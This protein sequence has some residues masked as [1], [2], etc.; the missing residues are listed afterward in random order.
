MRTNNV[1]R[2][3]ISDSQA[4]K[5]LHKQILSKTKSTTNIQKSVPSTA[6][7]KYKKPDNFTKMM[8][9]SSRFTIASFRNMSSLTPVNEIWEK[10]CVQTPAYRSG[11]IKS[12]TLLKNKT[13]N[14]ST[15]CKE[16]MSPPVANHYKTS[17]LLPD[18]RAA[19][20]STR[21]SWIP[22]VRP[23]SRTM[24][25][26][27]LKVS[28]AG[29]SKSDIKKSL[30]KSVRILGKMNTHHKY[31]FQNT[32]FAKVPRPFVIKEKVKLLCGRSKKVLI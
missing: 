17:I 24:A 23:L 32:Y 5:A 27:S 14:L 31:E 6:N 25:L 16:S 29:S 10:S 7:S 4:I 9:A 8:H 19:F 30:G 13:E 26:D 2:K 11:I 15:F 21:K 18:P 20:G 1:T 28:T 12:S 3:I 22:T